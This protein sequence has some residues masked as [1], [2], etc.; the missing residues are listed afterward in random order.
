MGWHYRGFIVRKSDF[1][2]RAYKRTNYVVTILQAETDT[3]LYEMI[4]REVDE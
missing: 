1:G 2:W 3:E 4:D